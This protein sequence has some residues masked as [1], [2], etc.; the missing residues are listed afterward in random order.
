[1]IDIDYFK[2]INDTLGHNVGD[3]ILEQVS[4]VLQHCV[5]ESDVVARWGGEEFVILCQQSSLPLV[6]SLCVRIAERIKRYQFTDNVQLTCS[7]GVAKLADNEPMMLCFERADRA[8]YRAKA[9][10]RNQMCTDK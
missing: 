2:D 7:F 9:Q 4:Q 6:E 1:M 10:G 8:L 3:R 5:R